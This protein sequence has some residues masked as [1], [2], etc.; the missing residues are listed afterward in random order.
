MCD[1]GQASSTSYYGMLLETMLENGMIGR[2][3]HDIAHPVYT[4]WDLGMSDSTA[5]TFFQYYNK[6]LSIIDY[7][8]THNIGLEPIVKQVMAKPYNM[9]WHFLP[10]D[11]TVRDS[12]AEQR[13]H[14]AQNYG[15]VNSS[16]LRREPRE[17]GI[18]R[19][20]DGIQ[21]MEDGKKKIVVGGLGNS[22]VN[23]ATTEDMRRKLMLYKRKFN[24]LTGDYEGPEHKT[25]SHAADSLRYVWVAIDQEF[26]PKT[27][28]FYYSPANAQD[29]YE[30]DSLTIQPSYRP[31]WG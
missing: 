25:E 27:G 29:S 7:F 12:D 14:K 8:E 28:E 2:H 15:L 19:V 18:Q 1:W 17:D 26:D 10:H 9:A 20:I 6:K 21:I 13:L 16:T 24:P 30:M 4:A 23:A 22:T 3:P 5:V 11:G 31:S